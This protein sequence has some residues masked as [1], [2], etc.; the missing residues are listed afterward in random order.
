MIPCGEA[1]WEQLTLRQKL[2]LQIA[3]VL[4]LMRRILDAGLLCRN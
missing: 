4:I 3:L 1:F 2:S